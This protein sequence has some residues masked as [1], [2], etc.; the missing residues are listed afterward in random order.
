MVEI[1]ENT[2]QLVTTGICMVI[3]VRNGF[4][5]GRRAWALLAFASGV[6]FLGDLY[7]ELFLIFFGKTP[8][9]SY[10]SYL[11]WN[12]SY[13]FFVLLLFELKDRE[14]RK[15]RRRILWM[16]P[17]FTV[18]MCIFYMQWGDWIGNITTA[19]LMTLLIWHAWSGL[20]LLKEQKNMDSHARKDKAGIYIV[21]LLFCLMEYAAWSASCFGNYDTWM[22]PYFWFEVILSLIFL[23]LPPVLGKAV[24]G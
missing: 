6:F 15:D 17:L 12:A 14:N 9:Y 13:L 2:F 22:Q 23:L 1:V 19:L 21:L 3:S 18:G 7:W 11:S 4:L 24:D 10:I 5:T 20:L 8:E 16:V